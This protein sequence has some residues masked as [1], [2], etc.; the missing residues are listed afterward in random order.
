MESRL[1]NVIW[2][3]ATSSYQIEGAWNQDGKG[4]S[5]WDFFCQLPGKTSGGATGQTACDHYHRWEEDLDL[6]KD[7]GLD[8]YR[9]SLSWPRILPSG[10]GGVNPQGL[11]FYHRLIDGLLERGIAPWVTLYHWDMPAALVMEKDG[12][13]NPASPLWFEEYA[14][15]CF[16]NFGDRVKNWITLNEPWVTSIL[17]YG[18]GVFAP[19]RVSNTEPY[20]VGHHL[21]LAHGRAVETYRRDFQPTQKGQI[22]L[23]LN[24][25]WREPLTDSPED[26]E[27]S[28][29]ALEFFLG[30]FADPVWKGD[31][32]QVMKDR[33][34]SRLPAFTP[35]DITLLKG[36]S[37]FFGLN[38]YTTLLAQGTIPGTA[39]R[40]TAYGNGGLSEDQDVEL[41]PDPSWPVTD[42][43]WAVVPW[44]FRKLLNWI[45]R[46]YDHPSIIVS[47][48]GCAYSDP[49][50]GD[51]PPQDSRR[52]EFYRSYLEA[53]AQAVEDGVD[54]AGYFAWSLMD[55]FEWAQGYT[56]RFGLIWVD[57]TTQKR[58]PKESYLWYKNF[59]SQSKASKGG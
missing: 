1:R 52:V 41:L 33:L 20:L 57:F 56:Q 19:G 16:D 21:L 23:S 47:E 55:N 35:E 58:I 12:W 53:A 40:G 14:R 5:Q 4:P 39:A 13:L 44:G 34:G 2:G 26:K 37:D 48:N 15:L 38:H 7:L 22:G 42:M 43:G 31:Y 6:M 24:C 25:D 59:I 28:Q 51:T 49:P 32:P 10:T 3:A 9:F 29:R 36:S 17:G 46:R 54:L 45:D 18:Q 50:S 8:A 27:A 30:W 11:D